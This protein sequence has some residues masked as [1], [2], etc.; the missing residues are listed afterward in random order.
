MEWRGGIGGLPWHG[1]FITL[2]GIANIGGSDEFP[3]RH[4][5]PRGALQALK[6]ALEIGAVQDTGCM[7]AN[8]ARQQHPQSRKSARMFGNQN[9]LHAQLLRDFT[10]MQSAATAKRDEGEITRIVSALH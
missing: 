6:L 5:R 8:L 2:A 7:I 9:S 4:I 1:E 10:S 3:A